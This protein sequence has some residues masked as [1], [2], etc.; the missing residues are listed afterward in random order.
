MSFLFGHVI[1]M[2]TAAHNTHTMRF[3]KEYHRILNGDAM[4]KQEES[5]K[6]WQKINVRNTLKEQSQLFLFS[7]IVNEWI[8]I[9]IT[10]INK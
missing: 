6:R 10:K 5:R 9:Y 3:H 2:S 4:S 8:D 7:F 1:I